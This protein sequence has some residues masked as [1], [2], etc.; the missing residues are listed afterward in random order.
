MRVWHLVGVCL[1][2]ALAATG[3]KKEPEPVSEKPVSEK[4]VSEKSVSEKTAPEETTVG[5]TE[6]FAVFIEGKKV[7]Y[8]IHNRVTTDGNV[9]TSEKVSITMSRDNV[10]VTINTKE[11]NIETTDGEPLGFEVV[12]ELGVMT[13]KLKGAVDEQG[14]VNL[15]TTSMGTEQKST[16]EWPSG[17]VMAEGLRLLT[18]KKGLKEGLEYTAKIFSASNLQAFD[19]EIRV[20]SKRNVDLLGRVVALREVV[21]TLNIQ[22]AGEIVS[23]GYV[24]EDLQVQKSITPM[25]GMQIEMVACA[26]EFALGKNDVFEVIDKMF[27]ASPVPLDNLGSAKSITYHLSPTKQTAN[28]I[29][30]SNDNQSVRKLK[31]SK[32]IVTVRPMAAPAG[33]KFP[34]KGKDK[35]ILEA[36]QPTRFLQSDHKEII[37]LARSAVGRTNDAAEAVRKIEAFVGKYIK[38]KDLSV[39]YASAA[40]VAASRQGDCSEHAVLAA[41]MCRAVGIP[42]QMVVGIAYVDDFAGRQGF[43][44][45]A[46]T[47]A[48][49]AG[50]WV[51]LDAAFKGTGRGGYD[52]GH[53]ALAVGNGEPVDFF[54]LATTLGQFKIDKI[55]VN[56]GN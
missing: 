47:Q 31:N 39:G 34:Y 45:H 18:L 42:A 7:G 30:P 15:T 53:I 26:K 25:A 44:G 33:A 48:Y 27:L 16:L 9:T 21:T 6:H 17:A 41:A 29:I 55:T 12:Q 36:M 51:G 4:S 14:R 35:T 43:G 3:C 13:M 38:N 24:D 20:G 8:A 28:L 54:N 2:L 37:A 23:T 1:V 22:G 32:V 11:T 46:W 40:E 50:K 10:P 52:A 5:E 19:A 49:V 56:R